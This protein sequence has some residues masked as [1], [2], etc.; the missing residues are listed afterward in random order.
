MIKSI[1]F[2]FITFLWIIFIS[3]PVMANADMK[4]LLSEAENGSGSSAISLADEYII[5]KD[6]KQA[7]H[8]YRFAL[9]KLEGKAALSL[10]KLH[11]EGHIMLKDPEEIKKYGFDLMIQNAENGHGSDALSLGHFYMYGKYTKKDYDLA[12]RWFLA[13]EKAG[14][15]M[16]SYQLG[17]SYINGLYQNISYR[18]AIRYFEKASN[19]GIFRATRQIAIAYH[20]GI[21]KSKN[22]DKAIE[23]YTKAA[24]Q[25]DIFAMRDLGNIYGRERPDRALQKSW[26]E[27]SAAHNNA[28][29][30]Y[31][32]G[33]FYKKINPVKSKKHFK[34]ASDMKH[35]LARIEIDETY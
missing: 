2:S 32:L 17:I 19:A 8:W 14:K 33:V 4:L 12:H 15:P 16:A 34:S 9:Y 20:T 13:A 6:Y 31:Y 3:A 22:I 27:K 23:Y 24:E 21:G 7:E 35:H 11:K 29:A 1:F 26:L 18:T 5:L 10:Y 25:G 30:N 28:D